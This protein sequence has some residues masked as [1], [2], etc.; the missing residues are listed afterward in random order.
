[1]AEMQVRLILSGDGFDTSYVTRETGL[2]PD[3]VQEKDKTHKLTEWGVFGEAKNVDF[4]GALMGAFAAKLWDKKD[5]LLRV[6]RECSAQWHIVVNINN[7]YEDFSP[8][9][10]LYLN[11]TAKELAL[12]LDADIRF[13]AV[14]SHDTEANSPDSGMPEENIKIMPHNRDVVDTQLDM[15][16]AVF[17]GY[18]YDELRKAMIVE[19][20]N[21]RLRKR[22]SIEFNSVL[23]YKLLTTENLDR[24]PEVLCW[25]NA[26]DEL[27]ADKRKPASEFFAVDL[28]DKA[29]YIASVITMSQ[30]S[31][32]FIVCRDIDLKKFRHI[33]PPAL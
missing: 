17:Q 18:S 11:N 1:M 10:S 27:P 23:Y 19:C 16:G 32:L 2:Q 8:A 24:P 33:V 26:P 9:L 25:E 6:G 5:V 31:E 14:Y 15:K 3:I 30:G 28:R 20:Y 29:S 12:C 21:P 7:R 13:D 22:L 4:A